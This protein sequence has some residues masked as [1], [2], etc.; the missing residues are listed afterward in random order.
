MKKEILERMAS[1][2]L[3]FGIILTIAIVTTIL[4]LKFP[5]VCGIVMLSITL[6]GAT[7]FWYLITKDQ[8][9]K[10]NQQKLNDLKKS[11]ESQNIK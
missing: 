4:F 10:E 7:F 11:I 2:A 1:D 9:K 3:F 5:V 6:I 8:I